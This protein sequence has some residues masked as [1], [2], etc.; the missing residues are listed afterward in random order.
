MLYSQGYGDDAYP[1]GGV[2]LDSSGNLYGVLSDGGQNGLGAV[3][4]LSPSGSSWTEQTIYNF[5]EYVYGIVP[6]GGVLIDPSGNLYGTTATGGSMEGGIVFELTP[7][8]GGWTFNTLY[9]FSGCRYC[10]PRDKLVMD[11]AGDLYRTTYSDGAYEMGSV[12]KLTLSKG[13]WTNTSL[14]DFTG[15]SDGGHPISSLVF[16]ANGNLY[17]TT[18]GGG[19]LAC[20]SGGCG[21]VFEITP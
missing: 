11:A 14:H 21:V 19:S 2:V 18:S 17:G 6:V 13:A 16:D 5:Y 8:N 10:G 20:S 12:F 15:G 7:A 1:Q 3:Y 4:Q 9:N